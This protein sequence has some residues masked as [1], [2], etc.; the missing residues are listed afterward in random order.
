M[1]GSKYLERIEREEEY[2]AALEIRRLFLCV[3]G[4]RNAMKSKRLVQL[5]RV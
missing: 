5:V 3:L 1:E 4:G 2:Q